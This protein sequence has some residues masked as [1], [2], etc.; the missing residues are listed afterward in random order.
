MLSIQTSLSI[1][2]EVLAQERASLVRF[3]TSL[4][5]NSSVA[6][7]LAQETLL[8]AWRN[9]HKFS[10]PSSQNAGEQQTHLHQWLFAIARNVCL[11]WGRAY[12]HDLANVVPFAQ[13]ASDSEDQGEDIAET[14]SSSFDIEVEL[15]R[16]ELARLLDR[17]L[18]LLPPVTRA[19]LIERYIH[20]SPYAE[21]AERLGLNEEA[22][23][24]RLHRGK[25]TLRRLLSTDFQAEATSIIP[26]IKNEQEQ[27]TN[28][29]CPMCN[30]ARLVKY[31]D[32]SSIVGFKCPTCWHIAVLN[33]PE[34]WGALQNPKAILNR[35]AV[36]T[37]QAQCL[38][39]QSPLRIQIVQAEDIPA[40][41]LR[42]FHLSTCIYLACT[43]CAYQEYNSLPHMTLDV[44]EASQFW[45]KHPRMHWL[46]A[47]QIDHG[48][49]PAWVSSFQ[50]ATDSARLDVIIQRATMR[51]LGIYER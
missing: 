13:Y 48:G 40:N 32:S 24:Q 33:R 4:T 30:N 45:R 10:A 15:E 38:W 44:P 20:E 18:A 2:Q 27:E 5:G 26:Q 41:H 28:I 11:R 51:I 3:C 22:L 49:V 9:L 50:S 47:Q 43:R 35:Q 34:V 42:N 31:T 39:C 14:L 36:D 7:D 25:L 8:E 23:A 12:H 19:V 29:W 21:I 1:S 37:L 6:E 46:P 17:A 16:D